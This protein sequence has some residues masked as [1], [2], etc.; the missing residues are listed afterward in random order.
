M[1]EEKFYRL[2]NEWIRIEKLFR[3][4]D[5]KVFTSRDYKKDL[6]WWVLLK[7]WHIFNLEKLPFPK[8]AKPFEKTTFPDFALSSDG[9]NISNYIEVTEVLLPG[10][11]RSDE[12]KNKKDFSNQTANEKEIWI[13]FERILK[14]KLTRQFEINTWLLLYHNVRYTHISNYGYWHNSILGKFQE[15]DFTKSR[16]EH[17]LVI[18]ASGQACVSLFPYLYIIRPEMD[19]EGTTIVD[20]YFVRTY[21]EY[22]RTSSR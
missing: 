14:K 3:K 21:D 4:R 7:L 13:S 5:G 20:Q 2:D 12:Y 22:K 18:D 10:R 11:K 16:Y 8:F 1:D 15:Y 6:E 19:D 9:I 17:I